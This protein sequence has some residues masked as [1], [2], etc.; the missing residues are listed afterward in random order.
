MAEK[1]RSFA[2]AVTWR[3]L[4]LATDF[5]I[6]FLFI[7]KIFPSFGVAFTAVGIALTSNLASTVT[8]YFHERAWENIS[9]RKD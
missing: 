8:Y 5:I 7:K 9:W 3:L 1:K 6:V 2:K 4:S